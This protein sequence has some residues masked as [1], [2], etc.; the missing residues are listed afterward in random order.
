MPTNDDPAARRPADPAP[1]ETP[2][3]PPPP[4]LLRD[5]LVLGACALTAGGVVLAVAIAWGAAEAAVGVGAAYLVYNALAARGDL[6]GALAVRLLTGMFRSPSA[7][8]T[9]G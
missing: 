7:P 2:G 3:G 6:S 9:S 5:G 8:P 4:A 1:P